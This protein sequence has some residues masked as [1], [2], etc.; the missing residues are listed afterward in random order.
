MKRWRSPGLCLLFVLLFGAAVYWLPLSAA[1][2]IG[3]LLA[4]GGVALLRGPRA[5]NSLLTLGSVLIGAAGLNFAFWLITPH[6]VNEGEVKTHTPKEWLIDDP[7]VGYKFQPGITV[8]DVTTYAGKPLYQQTYTIGPAGDRVTPGS[9]AEG[10]TYLFIGDSLIF[11]ETL[12]DDQTMVSQFAR[13]QQPRVHAVNLGVPGYALNNVVRALETGRYDSF[14]VGPVKAVVSWIAP[15]HI[16]RVTGDGE[17]L[18]KSP[19]YALESD[20]SVRFTGSFLHHRLTHPWAGAAYLARSQLPWIARAVHTSLLQDQTDLYIALLKR[21]RELARERFHAPLV[22]I[23]NWPE[24][25]VPGEND[26]EFVPAYRRIANLGIPLVSV[27]QLVGPSSS[28]D[29]F[30]MPHDGHPNARLSQMIAKA[31]HDKLAQD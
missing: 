13:M 9:G 7:V 2:A 10:P 5:R 28:W 3:G 27:R 6:P 1:L 4:Y 17:W 11:G 19:S 21:M 20:G 14:A 25:E 29:S 15:S 24:T 18:T 23:C 31:L 12:A 22:L 8:Q 16:E 30:Y 26:L